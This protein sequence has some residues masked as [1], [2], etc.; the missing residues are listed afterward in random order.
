M[1]KDDIANSCTTKNKAF[2][3]AFKKGVQAFLDG[4]SLKDCPY[5]RYATAAY[6][7][8]KCGPTFE[9]AFA[10][11]WRYGFEAAEKAT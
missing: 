4:K 6:G 2:I 10:K 8:G 11:Y 9:R 1:T 5:D 3:G 7:G